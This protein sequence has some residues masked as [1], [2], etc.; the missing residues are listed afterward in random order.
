MTDENRQQ[1]LRDELERAEAALRAADAL[2]GLDLH[3]DAVSRCYYAVYHYLR[4]LLYSRGV[5]PRSHAGAI[6]L[7]NTQLVRPGVMDASF[8]RLLSGLQRSRELADYDAA[9]RFSADDARAYVVEARQFGEAAVDL[10][11]RE[12]WLA[13]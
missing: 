1:N 13:E 9:V 8:N 7:F 5:E 4:A 6:H 10:L 2:I 11:T 12:G 3:A